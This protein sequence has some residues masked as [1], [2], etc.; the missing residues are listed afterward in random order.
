MNYP[1]F[2][3]YYDQYKHKIYSY[4]YYRSG[5]NKELAEDLTSEVFMKALEKFESYKPDSS[6]QSWVYAIAHNHLVD[7]FRKDKGA[8]VDLDEVENILESDGDARSSLMKRVASEEVQELLS[9]L[10]DE[11]REIVLLRYQQELPMQDIADIVGMPD[12]TVRVVIH[13][14]LAKLRKRYAV[15]YAS[16]FFVTFLF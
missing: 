5:R 6:F 2:E 4:L 3:A 9:Y 13:R 11:E 7:H 12:S 8:K 10:S 15:I 16:F 14:A 1:E